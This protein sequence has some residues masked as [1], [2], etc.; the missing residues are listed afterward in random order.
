MPLLIVLGLGAS[1]SETLGISLVILFLQL[2]LT[3]GA[4]LQ[5]D[6]LLG[7]VYGAAIRFA[8]N[9]SI[10]LAGII[11]ALVVLKAGLALAY[12]LVSTSLKNGIS[13]QVRVDLFDSLPRRSVRRYKK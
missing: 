7:L 6:N 8:G 2:L 12:S 1:A 10:G 4:G 13:D 3:E 11:C 9:S 5:P